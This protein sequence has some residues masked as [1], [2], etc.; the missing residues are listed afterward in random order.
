MDIDNVETI[1]NNFLYG[2]KEY[3]K[4]LNISNLYTNIDN[5]SLRDGFLQNCYSMTETINFGDLTGAY[6]Y[7]TVFSMDDNTCA[8]Y[9]SGIKIKGKNAS[10][11]KSRFIQDRDEKPFRKTIVV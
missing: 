10:D 4:P 5:I 2:C 3:N 9:T 1:D 8:A 6:V 11:I 7:D